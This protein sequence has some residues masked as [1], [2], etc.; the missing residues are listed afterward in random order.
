[1]NQRIIVL[2]FAFILVVI[3]GAKISCDNP[4]REKLKPAVKSTKEADDSAG[5]S[6]SS[7]AFGVPKKAEE[8]RPDYP[9]RIGWPK[10][11]SQVILTGDSGRLVSPGMYEVSGGV[12]NTGN[13]RA[14][15]VKVEITLFD[16][17]GKELGMISTFT[18]PKDI[19]KGRVGTYRALCMDRKMS[20]RVA[21]YKTNLMW[22]ELYRHK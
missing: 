5:G 10:E 11:I 13:M 4:V 21:R 20:K 8:W 22:T 12:K 6:G 1:M 19:E 2:L 7:L 17:A 14:I 15:D 18:F 9:N 16:A 3:A